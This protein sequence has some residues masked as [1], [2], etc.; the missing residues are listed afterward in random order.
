MQ[1]ME[2]IDEG[3]ALL[4]R[5]GV[6]RIVEVDERNVDRRAR[7]PDV[8]HPAGLL[9]DRETCGLVVRSGPEVTRPPVPTL[10]DPF[11]PLPEDLALTLRGSRPGLVAYMRRVEAETGG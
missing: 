2:L 11:D 5:R 4:T 6:A 10:D 8:R 7:A 1:S 3:D 9:R